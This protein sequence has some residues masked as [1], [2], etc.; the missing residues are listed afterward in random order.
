[1]R[2]LIFSPLFVSL[3]CFAPADHAS[4]GA[5]ATEVSG[6][7]VEIVQFTLHDGSAA[8][9][10]LAAAAATE[11]ALRRQPGFLRRILLRDDTG[12]WTDLVE[13]R[14]RPE[15]EA[16]AQAM[17]SDPSFAPFLSMIDM[18]TISMAHPSVLWRM[19]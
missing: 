10:F 14:S 19:D 2:S 5:S 12:G 4:A 8:D 11:A 7:V 3:V 18:E 6:P 16:A 1:M 13:W 15:A 17:M 9:D